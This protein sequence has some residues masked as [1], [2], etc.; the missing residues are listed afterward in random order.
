MEKKEAEESV[1]ERCSVRKTGPATAGLED[2]RRP[3]VKEC[4]QP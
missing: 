3:R 4:G 1:S 2:G